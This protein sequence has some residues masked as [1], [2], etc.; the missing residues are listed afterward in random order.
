MSVL[1]T[2]NTLRC[3]ALMSTLALSLS[4]TPAM[5]AGE[6]QPRMETATCEKPE[7]PLRWQEEG[8]SGTVMV[9]VLVDAD[10]KVMASKV[11][12]SSGSTRVDR[13]S[14]R[15]SA[16]CKFQPAA[17]EGQAVPSWTKVQYSWNL[18]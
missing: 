10:G 14:V 12:N 15:A 4:A 17:R 2:R 1:S 6:V 7:Y 13:A 18:E 5:A 9:A 8:E 3:A 11:V 16:R